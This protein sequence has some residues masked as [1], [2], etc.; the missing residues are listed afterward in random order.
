MK[1]MHEFERIDW[2]IVMAVVLLFGTVFASAVR[3]A[4]RNRPVEATI[5]ATR[6]DGRPTA[7]GVIFHSEAP[8]AA[9]KDRRQLGKWKRIRVHGT[10]G[11]VAYV[12]VADL[13]PPDAKASIDLSSGTAR[14]LGE[15]LLRR[16]RFPVVVED[17]NP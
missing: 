14:L 1:P 15:H 11:P 2:L 5:Y 6:Y 4:M 12:L 17:V 10:D 16:G 8:L 7:S 13:M 9:M 3:K